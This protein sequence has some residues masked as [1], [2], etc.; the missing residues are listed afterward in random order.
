VLGAH[1]G[2][3]RFL[4]LETSELRPASGGHREAV[5]RAAFTSDASRA[6]TA[7]ADGRV[8]VWDPRSATAAET[9]SGHS[10]AISALTMTR[11]GSTLYTAASDGNAFVWDVAGTRRLGRPFDI[12]L[13][14]RRG[15]IPQFAV[16]PDGRSL[17]V[18]DPGG[19]VRLVD[20]ATLRTLSKPLRVTSKRPVTAMRWVPD[21]RLLAI[22]SIDGGL[23]VVDPHT[24]EV[25]MR[26]PGESS[27][28][29]W[30]ASLS[31]SADGRV[32]A[33]ASLRGTVRLWALPSGRPI[34]RPF[35]RGEVYGMSLSSDGRAL[36]VVGDAGGEVIDVATRRRLR[37]FLPH[38]PVPDFAEHRPEGLLA[39]D[40]DIDGRITLRSA[41]SWLAVD[42]TLF[43][44]MEEPAPASISPDGVTVAMGT[45]N[46]TIRLW[47]A[48]SGRPI[49]VSL[50]GVPNRF[51]VPA[52]TPDGAYML[53]ITNVGRAYRWDLRTSSL[54]RYACAVAG[55]R[56]SRAEW[57]D[58]LPDRDY[59]PAC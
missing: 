31:F 6:V 29:G 17:A 12:P 16:S 44:D 56:L 36:A 20:V 25:V 28:A 33:A 3:V 43:G 32:M 23:S 40:P 10:G 48:S 11:D 37:T 7:D 24:G 1:D 53:A 52:F 19:S 14:G 45:T 58:V 34:G 54:A 9:L 51:V 26:R 38:E 49:G 8:I 4:D 27:A 13:G 39:S 18:A 2:S 15:L 35:E 30:G 5:V 50:P 47:D 59:D 42:G 41:Y 55:R 57:A 46:G 22:G 21:G